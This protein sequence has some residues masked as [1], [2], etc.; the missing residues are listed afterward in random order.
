MRPDCTG[1]LSGSPSTDQS[2]SFGGMPI[3]LAC[4]VLRNEA[5][6][7]QAPAGPLVGGRGH[8]ATSASI[9][10]SRIVIWGAWY[11][12]GLVVYTHHLQHGAREA[13]FQEQR[14]SL[15]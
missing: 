11:G 5:D 3:F 14:P 13:P 9:E 1:E 10:E 7:E 8:R 4:L 12:I 6:L 2:Q 15:G